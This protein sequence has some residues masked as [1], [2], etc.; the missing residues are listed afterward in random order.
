MK[1]IINCNTFLKNSPAGL[2]FIKSLFSIFFL[3]T[4]KI[5]LEDPHIKRY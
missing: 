5:M 1:E 2:F 4:Y 3:V